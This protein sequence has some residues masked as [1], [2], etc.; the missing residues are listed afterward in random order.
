[1]LGPN[2]MQRLQQ[3][4]NNTAPELPPQELSYDVN[5]LDFEY[6][7]TCEDVTELRYLLSILK[8]GK[9]GIF[10]HLEDAFEAKII[11]LSPDSAPISKS[12]IESYF[13]DW[14]I[15]L[16]QK[17]IDLK[18]AIN[19]THSTTPK[20]STQPPSK[21]PSNRIKSTDF[22]SWDKLDIQKELDAV[23]QN[24][25]KSSEKTQFATP[26]IPVTFDHSYSPQERAVL[27]DHEK[28][29]G[30]EC[31]KAQ[32][33]DDAITYYSRSIHL[34]PVPN[35]YTNRC[36]AYY[37]KQNYESSESDATSALGF[38]DIPSS[39]QYKAFYRRAMA[40]FKRGKYKDAWDDAKQA[41][42]M[43]GTSESGNL[44][45]EIE[46]K[47]KSVDEYGFLK[48]VKVYSP[49]RDVNGSTQPSNS[50]NDLEKFGPVLSKNAK[51]PV[52]ITIEEIEDFKEIKEPPQ[53]VKKK[54]MVIE[55]VE[56]DELQHQLE[57]ESTPTAVHDKKTLLTCV[58]PSDDQDTISMVLPSSAKPG[59]KMLIEEI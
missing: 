43:N 5:Q 8:S 53:L 32:E 26:K 31:Y 6:L 10:S 34:H 47:W 24:V 48:F 29:K 1:M 30:N 14:S 37:K 56:T 42:V 16:K 50:L 36:I 41:Q 25:P 44:I 19:P 55:E 58:T 40:R 20:T 3:V 54:K 52:K 51:P 22:R 39:L 38:K 13:A 35:V 11:A 27:A 18:A 49:D 17:D 57:L 23:Q 28:H 12:D 9:E 2:D 46:S 59:R 7:K 45:R 15:E 21:Q 33:L 4:V